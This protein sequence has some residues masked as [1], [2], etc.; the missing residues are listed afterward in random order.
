VKYFLSVM[1]LFITIQQANAENILSNPGLEE[2]HDTLSVQMPIGW[3]TSEKYS[4]GT[5]TRS[6]NVHTGSYAISLTTLD[7]NNVGCIQRLDIPVSGGKKYNFSL[8]HICTS[9]GGGAMIYIAEISP[10]DTQLLLNADFFSNTTW[11]LFDTNFTTATNT[12]AVSF[13]CVNMSLSYGL[14]L[15]IDDIN[16]SRISGVNENYK[17]EDMRLETYPNISTHF[18]NIKYSLPERTNVS[19]GIYDLTGRCVKTLVDGEKEAGSYSIKLEGKELTSGV[20]FVKM[21]TGNYSAT[22][23]LVLMR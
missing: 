14:S 16:L 22:K 12:V 6:T 21:K 17:S 19:L 4:A 13:S 9:F 1:V 8:Y 7:M 18:T 23:K 3:F 15:Y 20:Y 2:W 5:A 10:S 11:T